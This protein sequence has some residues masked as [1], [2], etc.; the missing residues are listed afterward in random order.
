MIDTTT[1]RAAIAFV[2]QTPWHGL[3]QALTPGA[4]IETWTREAG[5]AYD[6]LE[7]PVLYRAQCAEGIAIDSMCTW[8][9]RKVLHRSDTGAPLAVVSNAYNVVQ[10]SQVMDFFRTLV[11][12]GGFQ[13]ETAGALSDGRRVWALASVGDAAPVVGADLVKPYLLLGTS[14]DGTMATV[15]KFTAIR[16]V[17]NNTITAAVG[18]YSNGR[19]IKGESEK[20]TGYLKSAVR[21]LHSERFDPDAVRLQ[22]GIVANAFEGFLVQSRQL[23]GQGMDQADADTFVAELLRPYH[24]SARPVTESKAYVRIMQLFNGQAIG[25]DLAGV[26]GTRWAMLNAVTELVDHERGRSN[27]TRIESAWFGTGAALKARAAELLAE[28]V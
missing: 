10:P 3:G 13:L 8:P 1:G 12:L 5:L 23:A 20:N 15:A 28:G 16:V 11:D 19:V 18:G 2:N 9:A 7:S 26:A 4:S 17:C 22:L 6:V 24:S 14:Y 27:N 21:V 25:S